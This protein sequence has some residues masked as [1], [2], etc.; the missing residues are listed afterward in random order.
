MDSVEDKIKNINKSMSKLDVRH[1]RM[2]LL[3]SQND[4]LKN[5]IAAVEHRLS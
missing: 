4:D 1:E 5:K 3:K 2:Q